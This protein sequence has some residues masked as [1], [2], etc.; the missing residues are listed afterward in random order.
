MVTIV[1]LAIGLI[2]GLLLGLVGGGGSILTVPALIYLLGIGISPATTISLFVV[3]TNAVYGAVRQ[4]GSNL[5]V[6]YALALASTGLAGAQIG[7]WLNRTL[8]DRLLMAGFALLMLLVAGLMLRPPKLSNLRNEP[9]PLK[10]LWF[11]V[12]LIGLGL[13]FLTGLFG[14]G[15]G[16]LIVPSLVLLLGFPMRSAAATSL[17]VIALNSFSA[18]AG[19]WPLVGFDPALAFTLLAAGLVGTTVG[20]KLAK[21]IPDKTLRF[22]F[23]WVVI[24]IGI[25]IAIR[26]F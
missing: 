15:G 7:N 23:A 2:T 1:T 14:V 4:R 22:I 12:G 5:N 13:G 6:S 19:R 18:L 16:F 17:L 20:A 26:T 25:Y 10:L 11:K 8:P 21:L 9:A 3:G 24:A